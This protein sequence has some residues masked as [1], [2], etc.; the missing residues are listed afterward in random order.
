M[1]QQ[2]QALGSAMGLYQPQ[3]M[4]SGVGHQLLGGIMGNLQQSVGP[5]H[6]VF[7]NIMGGLHQPLVGFGLG[8][9]QQQFLGTAMGPQQLLGT[10]QAQACQPQFQGMGHQ[11]QFMGSILGNQ[12]QCFLGNGTGPKQQFFGTGMGAQQQPLQ[13]THNGPKQQADPQQLQ[14]IGYQM[15]QQGSQLQQPPVSFQ[16]QPS[17]ITQQQMNPG[18]GFK[19]QQQADEMSLQLRFKKEGSNGW[20]ITKKN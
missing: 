5:Q 15:L 18:G 4:G 16:Q 13:G 10:G 1:G 17:V 12:Q 19:Q 6:Q 11:Q 3:H 9:F 2:H 8:T 20:I 7:G 14:G